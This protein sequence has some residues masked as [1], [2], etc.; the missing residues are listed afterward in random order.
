MLPYAVRPSAPSTAAP[1]AVTPCQFLAAAAGAGVP[2]GGDAPA[3]AYRRAE[4]AELGACAFEALP[5]EP[6]PP[7]APDDA[8]AS[9]AWTAAREAVAVAALG[10]AAEARAAAEELALA[11]HRTATRPQDDAEAYPVDRRETAE[12][13]AVA[14]WLALRRVDLALSAAR[15]ALVAVP[16]PPCDTP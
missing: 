15:A 12:R 10:R 11:L 6:A 14:L 1:A 7:G 3:D 2:E 4:R 13:Q 8:D 16:A 5:V 9:P